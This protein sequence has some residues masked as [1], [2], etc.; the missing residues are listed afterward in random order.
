MFKRIFFAGFLFA[1]S[2]ASHAAYIPFQGI[3]LAVGAAEN[4]YSFSE[5]VQLNPSVPGAGGYERNADFNKSNLNPVFTIGYGGLIYDD[6]FGGLEGS[7]SANQIQRTQGNNFSTTNAYIFN[8]TYNL[9][10]KLGYVFQ[11]INMAYGLAGASKTS[12]ERQVSFGGTYAP[13]VLSPLH[14]TQNLYGTLFGIGIE[15]AYDQ[16]LH[17]AFEYNHIYYG[18]TNYNLPGGVGVD[19]VYLSQ[20][21]FILKAVY[22]L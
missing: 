17:F 20:D 13:L 18:R 19:K 1:F 3:Y 10:A 16:Y 22:F 6:I 5:K 9:L 12:L 11:D 15:R 2:A 7:L 14:Q 8:N 21:T 4:L